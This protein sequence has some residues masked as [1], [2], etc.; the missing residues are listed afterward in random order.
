MDH[1]TSRQRRAAAALVFDRAPNLTRMMILDHALLM[2]LTVT[3]RPLRLTPAP[4]L[5]LVP[6]ATYSD[7]AHRIFLAA[8]DSNGHEQISTP[9]YWKGYGLSVNTVGMNDLLTLAPWTSVARI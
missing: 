6:S 7:G 9:R 2:N 3:S 5:T 4:T 1:R 8:A